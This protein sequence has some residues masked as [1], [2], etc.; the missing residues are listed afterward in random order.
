MKKRNLLS[1]LLLVL[2]VSLSISGCAKKD[3]PVVEPTPTIEVTPTPE[4]PI[5][6]PEH[7]IFGDIVTG[8]IADGT[9]MNMLQLETPDGKL[10][11]FSIVDAQ[12]Y[13]G[14]VGLLIGEEVE[15]RYVGDLKE[16]ETNIAVMVTLVAYLDEVD[17]KHIDGYIV[18]INYDE[19][20]IDVDLTT[21]D[22]F[23]FIVNAH[24]L[25]GENALKV[26]DPIRI[27]Y[28]GEYTEHT[29]H[30]KLVIVEIQI[31]E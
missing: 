7:P 20:I 6:K 4:K 11:T 10:H 9:S 2:V 12:I 3:D 25:E 26:E 29:G 22:K 19:N 23:Y 13:A 21:G 5:E 8:L 18:D 17:A 1:L 30:N 16:D 27:Y 24:R 15:V 31:I 14:D 28:T